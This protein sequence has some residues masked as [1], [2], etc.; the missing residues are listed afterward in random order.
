MR[1]F[2]FS[3]DSV[4]TVRTFR[5]TEK[6]AVLSAALRERLLCEEKIASSKTELAATESMLQSALA[7]GSPAR[8][9]LLL[10]GAIGNQR[11]ELEGLV[12]DW[13]EALQRESAAREA[14]KEAQRACKALLKLEDRHRERFRKE[15][16]KE[17]ELAMQE[18]VS[19]RKLLS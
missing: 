11:L 16:E 2:Q 1:R 19:A 8:E 6:A 10:Q 13:R 12:E 14:V 5:K 4:L 9:V 17:D 18:F 15:A 7:Q 3:L